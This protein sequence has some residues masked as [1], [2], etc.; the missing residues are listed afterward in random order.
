MRMRACAC[1][2]TCPPPRAVPAVLH[3][4]AH[5]CLRRPAGE[6]QPAASR[7]GQRR[8]DRVAVG[9]VSQ[10]SG[11]VASE[12][13]LHGRAASACASRPTA[14]PTEVSARV[15]HPGRRLVVTC[16]A[17][18]WV[19]PTFARRSCTW[20]ARCVCV[21][22]CAQDVCG[23]NEIATTAARSLQPALPAR[24]GR[25]EL[26]PSQTG[27][28]ARVARA[29]PAVP[30]TAHRKL[31]LHA[32]APRKH[33]VVAAAARHA[34]HVTSSRP[35]H[36]PQETARA[37]IERGDADLI[38]FGRLFISN[39]DLPERI[40]NGWPLAP[41]PDRKWFYSHEREGYTTW[42]VY[43]PAAAL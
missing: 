17:R 3:Q 7:G 42:P 14:C 2:A 40:A 33:V 39:P 22:A 34:P 11:V 36:A 13:L 16:C 19:R 30:R 38:A 1:V 6:P 37:A 5:G 8:A 9:A 18:Q 12:H 43:S 20:R 41:V 27:T 28:A 23:G 32:G 26:Q 24:A 29:A 35:T 31:G 4:Q 15:V 25:R 10:V 21:C